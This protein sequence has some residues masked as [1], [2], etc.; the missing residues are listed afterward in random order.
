MKYLQYFIGLFTKVTTGVIIVCAVVL[1]V[2]GIEQW[3]SDILWQIPLCGAVTTF[4]SMAILPDRDFSRRQ[5]I[6][7]YC[8]HFVLV[9]AFILTV[10][11][12][13][14]WYV[15]TLTGCLCMMASIAAV[16]AFSVATTYIGSRRSADE[17]N[18]ALKHRKAW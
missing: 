6:V 7:R 8:I 17:L 16:Y 13:F 12:L 15:P 11:A 2:L 5:W 9:S 10:G 4:L 18:N 14:G 1:K 3:T